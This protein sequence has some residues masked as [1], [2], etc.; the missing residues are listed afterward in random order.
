MTP[1]P[2]HAPGG[3]PAGRARAGFAACLA[4]TLLFAG[5]AVGGLAVAGVQ[6]AQ[7]EK[8]T[9]A[10]L[11]EGRLSQLRARLAAGDHLPPWLLRLARDG[12]ALKSAEPDSGGEAAGP[13]GCAPPLQASPAPA[14]QE[15]L[16]AQLAGNV[17]VNER[18]GD[19]PGSA[20]SEESVAFFGNFGLCGW[21]D[22]QGYVTAGDRQGVGYTTD[23]GATWVDAGAP[24]RPP[25]TIWISDPVIAVDQKTGEFWFSALLEPTDSTNAIAVV[26]ATFPGGVL[27]WDAPV[28]VEEVSNSLALLDKEWL[29]ADSSS[30][31]L[32]LVYARF[33]PGGNRLEARRSLS[34]GSS[35]SAPIALNAVPAEGRVQGA[36]VVVGPESEVY[37]TWFQIGQVDQ[38]TFYVKKSNDLGASFGNQ[39]TV[40]GGY[41]NYFGNGAPGFNRARAIPFPSIA[42]DGSQ[43]PHRGRVY[44]AWNE[45]FNFYDDLLGLDGVVFEEENDDFFVRATP[46]TP[47]QLLRGFAASPL[48]ADRDYYSFQGLQGESVI[49]C[50]DSLS[51]TVTYTLVLF[52]G[53]DT[54]TRLA[55][56]GDPTRGGGSGLIVFTLPQDGTY[57]LRFEVLGGGPS[58]YRIATGTSSPSGERA[59][60]HRDVFV[61]SSDDGLSWNVP[62]RVN[63]DPP[64]FDNWLPEVAVT[65]EGY[66]YA[67]W[68]DWREDTN[69]GGKSN[70]YMTRSTNGGV[71]WAPNLKVTTAQTVWTTVASNLAPNQGDYHS[72]ASYGLHLYP[73]WADGRLGD[74]D[75]FMAHWD[76]TFHCLPPG[77]VAWASCCPRPA[78][79]ITFTVT[80]NSLFAQTYDYRLLS[81][82][83]W[84][85]YP[86]NGSLTVAAQTTSNLVIAAPAPDSAANG[87]NRL[88][89]KVWLQSNPAVRDSCDLNYHDVATAA[90]ASLVSARV[91]G[92]Q[93]ELV[94]WVSSQQAVRIYRNAGR[95]DAIDPTGWSL[96]ATRWPEGN[97]RLAYQDAA[98]EVDQ[99]YG[100]RL[101]LLEGDSEVLAGEVWVDVPR[102][103]ALAL[104]GARPNPA[105]EQ[106]A[107]SF[108]LPDGSPAQLELWD[109]S[110]R[111][112]WQREVGRLGAGFHVLALSPEVA[113]FPAG[114]YALRL[115]QRG[116]TLS[117]K[118]ALLR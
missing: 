99:R 61:A 75:V 39:Q 65:Q 113:R 34:G 44:V 71:S 21:N 62:T 116:R 6:P 50:L 49:F 29:A 31:A 108:A 114:V 20:Q 63:D 16:R 35:W 117:A 88:E 60:D 18:F 53:Q 26:R 25:G 102:A 95:G 17:L 2:A 14:R 109:L 37:V 111:R 89:L 93:V 48:P 90:L 45:S 77:D 56:A 83:N 74:P 59:R 100:Y 87:L 8:R 38:D 64:F 80:N 47:G 9:S 46:F 94:W 22:G 5:G 104:Y 3:P 103:M 72:L 27:T 68:Y 78:T 13:A 28:V 82:R 66:A 97:G 69:C 36:R 30:G 7:V 33:F 110:G 15:G 118:L 43:G 54:L 115:T 41:L 42:V 84:S 67:S 106:V 81:T 23:G 92:G 101:G 112:L 73:C 70:I 4:A 57:Y 19:D 12:E 86:I 32:H 58:H 51:F 55:L 24:P 76:L 105:S 10:L 11:S 96:L 98:V 85:G 91:S 52:C 1:R 40:M 107:V 79:N